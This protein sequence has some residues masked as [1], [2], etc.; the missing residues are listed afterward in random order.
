MTEPYGLKNTNQNMTLWM[1]LTE[2]FHYIGVI[3]FIF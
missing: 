2:I 1:Y 3:K